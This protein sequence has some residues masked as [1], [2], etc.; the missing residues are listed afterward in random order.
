MMMCMLMSK[1]RNRRSRAGRDTTCYTHSSSSS[2][3]SSSTAAQQQAHLQ[4]ASCVN[5]SRTRTNNSLNS[6]LLHSSC[7]QSQNL[8]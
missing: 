3:C 4:Q 5:Q 1:L 2:S 7:S 6:T 8:L